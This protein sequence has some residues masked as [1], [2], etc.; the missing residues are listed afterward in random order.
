MKICN[1]HSRT[2]K[3]E[4]IENIVETEILNRLEELSKVKVKMENSNSKKIKSIE[5]E[6]KIIDENIEKLLDKILE[7][8]DITIK[9]INKKVEELDN[10]K[11]ELQNELNRITLEGSN[12]SSLEE[13]FKDAN[14]IKNLSFDKKK[15][16]AKSLI[17]KVLIRDNEID[18]QWKVFNQ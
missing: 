11:T 8:N 4:E 12:N 16:I 1:G 10:K 15:S 3:V 14:K 6:I 18:I 17:D 13:V 7:S 2:I 5:T 9:Y